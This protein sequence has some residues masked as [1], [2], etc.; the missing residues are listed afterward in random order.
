MNQYIYHRAGAAAALTKNTLSAT[1]NKP[2]PRVLH[3][4]NWY[5]NVD[6]PGETPFIRRHVLSLAPHFEQQVWHLEVRSMKSDKWKLVTRNLLADRT[7]MLFVRTHRW[8]VIEWLTTFLLLWAWVSRDRSV[9]FDLV[10]IHIA[11][12]LGLR[13]RLIKWLFKV[14]LV[15]TEQWS[16]YHY[17]FN[18]T[19]KG[20]DRIRKIFAHDVPLICVSKALLKDIE[21]FSGIP[22]QRAAVVDNV[23]ETDF[24]H[25]TPDSIP[26]PGRFF[27]IAG[28]RFPKRPD[29][30][31]R[32]A[33]QL[34][35]RGVDFQLRLAGDGKMMP[36]MKALI[37]ELGLQE[38]VVLLGHLDPDSVAQEMRSAHALL[39]C[40]DYETYSAVCA[41]SLCMGTPVI[42][43]NVGGISE[44]M[45]AETGLLVEK[46]EVPLWTAAVLDA[47]DRTLR[48]NRKHIADHMYQRAAT[49]NV[50]AR[51]SAFL[52][53]VLRDAAG[54]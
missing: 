9:R 47:W 50:G 42:A 6:A 26:Q 41:E 17:S 38:R 46:N 12:P 25:W 15:F 10:N 3:I 32:M 1:E 49:V 5:P 13:T 54:K 51:Y 34:K 30:L 33:G 8:L 23:A 27:A 48:A 24:F 37:A 18:S 2:R 35:D 39:H 31:I 52:N 20:L 21:H 16:G 7:Y 44:Y 40:S 45:T 36:E 22:Q 4:C 28:W 11:Y 53:E 14:P 19:S 43:S 29:V